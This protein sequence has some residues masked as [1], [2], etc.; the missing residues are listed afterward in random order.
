MLPW[1]LVGFG[2]PIL[3]HLLGDLVLQSSANQEAEEAKA[4]TTADSK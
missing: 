4:K 2:V 1:R 3:D